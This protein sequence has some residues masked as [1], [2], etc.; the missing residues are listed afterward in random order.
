MTDDLQNAAIL[1]CPSCGSLMGVPDLHG[2]VQCGYC[3]TKIVLPPTD[4]TKENK[5]LVRYKELCQVERQAKNWKDLLKYASEILEIDPDNL[6]AWIDKALAT[7]SLSSGYSHRLDEARG[8]LQKAAELSPDDAR[9]DEIKTIIEDVQFKGYINLALERNK[10]AVDMFNFRIVNSVSIGFLGEAMANFIAALKVKPNDPYTL[11]SIKTVNE[12]AKSKGIQWTDAEV[13][14][15]VLK[16]ENTLREQAA[17][18]QRAKAQEDAPR[19]VLALKQKLQQREAELAKLNQKK[20]GFFVNMEIE[21]VQNE[22]KK[23]L[24]EISK[25]ESTTKRN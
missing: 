2:I 7:G 9:I 14:E 8:Y 4:A 10:A 3:G 21:D 12:T 16:V 5:N 13:R 1:K 17:A 20:R 11:Q 24:L 19:R 22:I 15:L 25:L 18:A 6:D 23:I